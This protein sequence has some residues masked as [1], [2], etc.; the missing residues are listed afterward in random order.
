MISDL[1][2]V[3]HLC[4]KAVIYIR[5]STP[6]QVI[7]NQESLQLQYALHQRAR[8]LGWDDANIEVID[9]DLG[10]S[11]AAA[12]H[13]PG[14]KDLIARV[15]LGEVGIIL[16]L[17][18]TRLARNCTDWYPLLDLCGYRDCLIGD[19]DGVYAPGSANGRLLLGLKGTISEIELHTL[20]GRLTAGLLNKA[21]RGE[22][23]LPLPAGLTRDAGGAVAKDP[24]REVQERIALVFTTFL[25]QRSVGRV[26]RVF[27][28]R[29][30]GVPRRDRFGEVTWRPPS[31]GV[32]AGILK[33]PAYAGAFVYGR[34]R[35]CHRTYSSG[36]LVTAPCPMAE[37][38]I[39]VKD[40]YPAYVDWDTFEKIQA[41][42]RDNRAEYARNTTRG[43]PRDGAALLHGIVWCG[44]CGHKM[45]VQY[46]NGPRYVCNSLKRSHGAPLCQHVGA[47]PIDAA[48]VSAFF[49]AVAP[50]ELE[51]WTRAEQ[52]RLAAQE[53]LD[54]AEAQQVERLRYQALLAERQYNKVDPDNRLVAG[55][56]EHRWELALRELRQAEEALGRR[57]AA[58]AEP[59]TLTSGERERFLALGPQLP[60]LW[61][62][63]E[64]TPAHKKALLRCLVDKVVVTRAMR[65]R[66]A[67]RIVWRGGAVSELEVGPAVHARTA[68][69]RG[70]E[71][72][73]R[74]LELSRQGMTDAAIAATLTGEGFR[75]A[76]RL[77]VPRRTVTLIRQGHRLMKNPAAA[78]PRSVPDY[79]SVSEIARKLG[80]S[81]HW[82]HRRIRSGTIAVFRDAAT[83][84]RLFPDT[85]DT[86]TGFKRLKSG[87]VDHLNFTA[88]TAK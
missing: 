81:P 21:G 36:K 72:E 55:E 70:A 47:E 39:V 75:S 83:Q 49:A 16:S 2:T 88:T 79:L 65:D 61:Q 53:A 50:A 57:R 69:S 26:M 28:Q 8:E 15:T 18:V 60:V 73:A 19:R 32:I 64:V 7:S 63:P 62:H 37:W 14:F 34:T 44:R 30:L 74:I 45:A 85:E 11:G 51:L 46:R 52:A 82:I 42:L 12:E 87:D 27:R 76:R 84:R 54:R 33:N 58:R 1:V 78:R 23:A 48:V 9:T 41:T 3:R 4:R 67:V 5:Q 68:L 59:E 38:R 10:L 56:L 17:E 71:M 86:L 77:D 40:K 24:D 29:G 6:H 20:R 43:V 35:S 25:E 80:V 66:V 22:L 31:T 13:R